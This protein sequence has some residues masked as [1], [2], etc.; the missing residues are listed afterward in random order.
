MHAL[1]DRLATLTPERRQVLVSRLDRLSFTQ[2]RLWFLHQLAPD[3]PVYNI[4]LPLQLTGALDVPVLARSLT[5]IAA[6]HEVLRTTCPSID[7]QPVQYVHRTSALRVPFVDLEG[8]P[9]G[10]IDAACRRVL[11]ADV[12][13]PIDVERGPLWRVMLVR[14]A[15]ARHVLM[16]TWHHLI[17]DSW[18]RGVFLRELGVAYEGLRHGHPPSLAPL[19]LQYRHFARWQRERLTDGVLE[20]QLAYWRARFAD[21]P[22]VI[23]LAA[24]RPRPPKPSYRGA[25]ELFTLPP[26]VTAALRALGA[27][28][29]ITLFMTL[30]AG[31]ATLLHKYSGC[32][33]VIIGTAT[34]GRA[35][36]ELEPLIG[37]FVNTLALRVSLAGNPSVRELLE[38]V[39]ESALG[40]YANQDLPFDRLVH[41]CQ[42][43]RRLDRMPLFQ[44]AVTLQNTPGV[45]GSRD[46]AATLAVKEIAAADRT[47]SVDLSLGVMETADGVVGP[48]RYALDLFDR[49]T[50]VRLLEHL[51]HLLRQIAAVPDARLS[52][53]SLLTPAERVQMLEVWNATARDVPRA[54]MP[55][56]FEARVARTPDAIALVSRD[57]Q[58]TYA[59][60]NRRANQLAHWL[61]GRRIG[62]ESIVGIAVPRS[63]DWIVIPLAVWKAGAA[64]LPL[65]V[66]HPP[67]RLA[68]MID[69][70]RPSLILTHASVR[71]RLPPGEWPIATVD[72]A[73]GTPSRDELEV[74]PIV[75]R[76]VRHA[77]YVIYTS[78]STGEPKGVVVTHAGL[79]SLAATHVDRF[80]PSMQ[81][82]VL[83][84]AS[85]GF[86]A[87]V[88]EIAMALTTG[89][90]L[91]VV[92]ADARGGEALRDALMAN[93]ITHATLP[94]IVLATLDVA[95][96]LP[97]TT[98][99]VA[100]ESC[101]PELVARWSAGRQLVNAYGPTETTVCATI[102]GAL[103]GA[104]APIGCPVWNTQVYVLD[105]TLQPAPVGVTGE[106]YVGGAGLARGY[107]RRPASTATRFIASPFGPAGSR[108]Y[109]T[110]D[111]VRWRS[112]GQLAFVG[113]VDR[114]VKLRGHRIELGE[115]EAVLQRQ[116]D[117][118][119]A[120]AVVYTDDAGGRRLVAYVV[121]ETAGAPIAIED[122]RRRLRQELPEPMAPA[123]VIGLPALPM[124]RNG[125]ID[126]GRLPA[127]SDERPA[128]ADEYTA[129]R[130]EAEA[131]LA[132]VWAQVLRR[133]RVGIHDN[134][135][136]LGGDS[137]LSFQIIARA[138]QAGWKLAPSDIFQH[139][140]IAA[141]AY[142]ARP[143]SAPAIAV[144]ATDGPAPLLPIQS[145]FLEAARRAP[146]HY[147]QQVLLALDPAPPP[148]VLARAWAAVLA[149]HDALR[150]SFVRTQDGWRQTTVA[151]GQ[152]AHITTIDLRGV[153]A[154]AQA[155]VRARVCAVVQASLNLARGPLARLV[156]FDGPADVQMFI[157]A[158]HLVMDGV[159][160]RVLLADL[161][162][163]CQQMQNGDPIALPHKTASVR[164][165]A[166]ALAAWARTDALR[167][168]IDLW[169]RMSEPA[170]ALPRDADGGDANAEWTTSVYVSHASRD[171]TLALI[172]EL[173]GHGVAYVQETLLA[174][175]VHAL[176]GWTRDAAWRIDLEGH[177]RDG[178]P[179]DLDVSRTIGWFTALYPVRIVAGS[180]PIDTLRA[181][182][183][184]VRQIPNGG[185]G[186]GV[187]RFVDG[188]ADTDALRQSSGAAI[189]FNYLGQVDQVL[190]PA[191]AMRPVRGPV[192]RGRDPR[193]LR[194]Y[195][196]EINS[197][198]RGGRLEVAW[199]YSR[200]SHHRTTIEMLADRFAVALR[201]VIADA[202]DHR[203]ARPWLVPADFP[204]AAIDQDELSR[205]AAR[206]PVSD[207][208]PLSPMQQGL[209]FHS[210]YAVDR[211]SLYAIQIHTRIEATLDV[212]AFRQAWRAVVARHDVL[213]TGF[214]WKRTGE[215]LQIVYEAVDPDD[216]ACA[217]E[218]W[219]AVP[220]AQ[221][222]ARQLGYLAEEQRR[223]FDFERPPLARIA[224]LRT[225]DAEWHVVW[226]AH[227]LVLDGWSGSLV[228]AD[229][230]RAY[231]A[232]VGG[233]AM[234][235]ASS[236]RYRDYIAWLQR[237]DVARAEAF[238]RRTM[239]GFTSPT[240]LAAQDRNAMH[241]TV[242][243]EMLRGLLSSSHAE[244][245]QRIGRARS[246]T[247]NTWLVGAW[248]LV[249]A[250][251]TRR[252]DVVFGAVVSGRPPSVPG[253][254]RT[255]G[256]F[257]NTLPVR[258]SVRGSDELVPWLS[259]LQQQQT[260]ARDYE[261][262]PLARMQG[263]SAVALDQPLFDTLFVYESYPVEMSST[264]AGSSGSGGL[265]LAASS[266][267]MPTT[268]PVVLQL[269][270]S[271]AGIG[272][273][274]TFN[275]AAVTKDL[276]RELLDAFQAL[277]D[278]MASAPDSRLES[279]LELVSQTANDARVRLHERARARNVSRLRELS[280][281]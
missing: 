143:A 49:S 221:Q 92:P 227:H 104:D 242:A 31:W 206:G 274:L 278:R 200:A 201:A 276:A 25:D 192:G 17:Y 119:Q 86:D 225:G 23:D 197:I 174:A 46:A 232:I 226:T 207:I 134:F 243:T 212:E 101:A 33:D 249:L 194:E 9:P 38:R 90:A 233:H 108:L 27:P 117:V 224:L 270:P 106:L 183:S 255:A 265:R 160:W 3:V 222:E 170:A 266:T 141:L 34:S 185:L 256:L 130:T 228:I 244:A 32:D 231:Q 126:Y 171:E 235:A 230:L 12:Q 177:G 156:V 205:L 250:H 59:G 39:R 53:L 142:A 18:S 268:Y 97:L 187:L 260:E 58:L 30:V 188:T 91:V 247:L 11:D 63:L 146:H 189:V 178:A 238:W 124:T 131:A 41:E 175:L 133:D 202:R 181:V 89:A 279:L 83:Q 157:V 56:L 78:G 198:V 120:A 252:D 2:E 262:T 172:Q 26:D 74:N 81:S 93:G 105:R 267:V 161:Q 102:S 253:I 73:D 135:F 218:D 48:L 57:Q 35:R 236:G 110:G 67:E 80:A 164:Q 79:A 162:R 213:R 37:C 165:W 96:E 215:P 273:E 219:R 151:A 182:K 29:G 138:L 65:D 186:Y 180:E 136:A 121:L 68:R 52:T 128:L 184:T 64:Y 70:A 137:I 129:P 127:P 239:D 82:R 240:L 116:P 150:S 40:A 103:A 159:S 269:E 107:R 275:A 109:R 163:A 15:S 51:T 148:L 208:Y 214:V 261:Y 204:L 10:L 216:S 60:L 173:P 272:V 61:V 13:R 211:S 132:Q 229:V 66:E 158:H 98:L 248:A 84:F 28:D 8:L 94:P 259:R 254:D 5:A 118:R 77:A 144:D 42:P 75:A 113:R 4:P 7:G 166:N 210:V 149:H 251:Y 147:N 245:L 122:L 14:I 154:A 258:A 85:L 20:A 220:V 54:T 191:G 1:Q 179:G 115:V 152:P 36:R 193:Q 139:Q 95:R 99:V 111:R 87:A 281:A 246:L 16:L 234:P 217:V 168:E 69:D 209:L 199:A 21:A 50:A 155:D 237:Q 223:G 62:P 264:P 195:D 280:T 6:R 190:E 76:D 114:Q 88:W 277:V 22:P 44:S 112:D 167:G 71:D 45:G 176:A 271:S 123:V 257:I 263:W 47:A 169:T 241:R 125:K 55:E 203:Q 145:R 43:E 140:T 24:D 19:T 72:A 196:L 153:D 100:G